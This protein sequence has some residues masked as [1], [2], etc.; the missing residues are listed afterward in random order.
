VV[1][2]DGQRAAVG[3]SLCAWAL[4]AA[5]RRRADHP[6]RATLRSCWATW[7][8]RVA[9]STRCAA[10]QTSRRDRHRRHV[11]RSCPVTWR[12]RGPISPICQDL[13]E[14][15]HADHAEQPGVGER[16]LLFELS[17]CSWSASSS[18]LRQG[19]TKEN[20]WGYQWLAQDGRQ[21]SWLISTTTCIAAS[22]SARAAPSRGRRG[23]SPSLQPGRRRPQLLQDD[24]RARQAQVDGGRRELTRSRRDLWK[25]P[26]EYGGPA[27]SKIQTEVFQLSF[28]ADSRDGRASPTR[29]GRS[30]ESGKR[31]DAPGDA[32]TDQEV[33]LSHPAGPCASFIGRRW[34]LPEQVLNPTW[35]YSNPINPDLGE[36]LKER[37]TARR[38]P[39]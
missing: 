19:A 14:G 8:G 39:L 28:A 35:N 37:S 20:D 36:V 6:H 21:H 26:K 34:A 18:P 10:T 16:E 2:F 25:A 17:Q 29:R 3:T 31:S 38:S 30:S 1:T 15:S 13:P 22:R 9:A 7:A 11:S 27:T 33:H 5:F 23:C 4:D 12:R 24:Q 32:K